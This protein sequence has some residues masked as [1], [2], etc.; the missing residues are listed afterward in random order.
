MRNSVGGREKVLPPPKNGM[1]R[2]IQGKAPA[3]QLILDLGI[4]ALH[5]YPA[6]ICLNAG[7]QDQIVKGL[8]DIVIPAGLQRVDDRAAVVQV[9]D[10]DHRAAVPFP[11][12]RT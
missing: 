12:A 9:A 5:L 1:G 4:A 11:Q 10:K 6:E 7:V 2:R 3:D 8:C